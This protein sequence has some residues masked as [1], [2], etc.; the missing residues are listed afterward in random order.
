MT[1]VIGLAACSNSTEDP[2]QENLNA[3]EKE[4]GKNTESEVTSDPQGSEN[5]NTDPDNSSEIEELPDYTHYIGLKISELPDDVKNN[6]TLN[7]YETNLDRIIGGLW[8]YNYIVDKNGV[9]L[10]EDWNW[11]ID[12]DIEKSYVGATSTFGVTMKDNV[13]L[14]VY[15][16]ALTKV[17]LKDAVIVGYLIDDV[18]ENCVKHRA[19]EFQVTTSDWTA[20]YYKEDFPLVEYCFIESANPDDLVYYSDDY[21]LSDLEASCERVYYKGQ[22]THALLYKIGI[23]FNEILKVKDN[24]LFSCKNND[25]TQHPLNSDYDTLIHVDMFGKSFSVV[26]QPSKNS[27]VVTDVW[28]YANPYQYSVDGAEKYTDEI[29]QVEV[30]H[31]DSVTGDQYSFTIYDY[32]QLLTEEYISKFNESYEEQEGKYWRLISD[33]EDYKLWARYS[34]Y[35]YSGEEKLYDVKLYD[36]T[37]NL[38]IDVDTMVF[39]TVTSDG[40]DID[41][42]ADKAS[43]AN[44]LEAVRI[45]VVLPEESVEDAKNTLAERY[46]K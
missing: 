19:S 33:N 17:P 6:L 10:R 40:R 30:S 34:F 32:D 15:N 12:V 1:L 36:K 14:V 23:G 45:T 13:S 25:Y 28:N 29:G 27:L 35:S 26:K 8:N 41:L 44:A 4:S 43:L 7:Y 18:T 16:E 20:T 46:S 37:M 21:T 39:N 38:W 5:E 3:T 11:A 24:V 31:K 22:R 2:S 9:A 42:V